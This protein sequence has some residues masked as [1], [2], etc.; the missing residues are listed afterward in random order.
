MEKVRFLNIARLV[1][2]S[3]PELSAA[4][5]AVLKQ[6]NY[7]QG[8]AV[9]DFE[10]AFAEWVQSSG[11][12]RSEPLHCV[13]VANGTDAI[14]LAAKALDLAPG[15]E[16]I[17]PAMTYAATVSALLNAGLSVKL[18]DVQDGYWTIDPKLLK[19][20]ITDQTKLVVPV[21]LYGQMCAM[22]EIAQLCAARSV[23]VLE[24]AAQSHG[25]TWKG[26][27]VGHWGDIATY[28]FY[29]GKNLGAMGD[30]GA[31]LS[32][33]QHLAD[34]CRAFGNQGGI[35][36]YEHDFVGFNSRL[37]TVQAA[38]LSVRLKKV[39]QQN[40]RRQQ[41]ADRYLEAWKGVNGLE[42][43]RVHQDGVHT[44]HLFVVLVERREDFMAFLGKKGI[45]C[46][47][48]YPRSINQHAAYRHLPFAELK[49]PNA[50]R[51][52]AHGVSLPICPTLTENEVD[53]V[54][55]AVKEYFG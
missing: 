15:S 29:P 49:F 35:K 25:S 17:V 50:E 5:D 34:R 28:S 40:A 23:R 51:I 45:D 19:G 38:F 6:A 26:K 32:R 30:A 36:K 46:G 53:R 21:H 42:V 44:W 11:Q 41:I 18:V 39:T 31:V 20:A 7:I 52:A 37:D 24:D 48:H 22:D 43:P 13:G 9:Y 4:V 33:S 47:V 1:E 2:Q 3:Y 55:G 54:I 16:A 14:T 8:P 10:K 12:G 27:P